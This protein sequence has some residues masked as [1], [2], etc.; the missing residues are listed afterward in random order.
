MKRQLT[1]R[2]HAIAGHSYGT[3]EVRV[4]VVDSNGDHHHGL[5][6]LITQ[7]LRE[8]FGNAVATPSDAGVGQATAVAGALS[9]PADTGEGPLSAREREVLAM[10]AR[11]L[12]YKEIAHALFIAE[13]TVKWH[14]QAIYRKLEVTSRTEAVIAGLRRGI[15]TLD[16]TTPLT[17]QAA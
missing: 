12:R 15:V 1:P 3:P 6:A 16:A 17:G 13:R 5:R 14:A 7:V 2:M 10:M 9:R 8:E 11:G 4:I